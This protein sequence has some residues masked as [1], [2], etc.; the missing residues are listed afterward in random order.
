[1]TNEGRTCLVIGERTQFHRRGGPCEEEEIWCLW[2]HE[3]PKFVFGRNRAKINQKLSLTILAK[4]GVLQKNRQFVLY[5]M[6]LKCHKS[7]YCVV[8]IG[9]TVHKV[10]VMVSLDNSKDGKEVLVSMQNSKIRLHQDT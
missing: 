6:F 10:I 7:K 1:M 3:S 2:E 4:E 5:I 8:L 9:S